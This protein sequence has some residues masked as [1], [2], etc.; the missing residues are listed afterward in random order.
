MHIARG[1]FQGCYFGP[2][3]VID[4]FCQGEVSPID[5]NV[6]TT[7]QYEKLIAQ[8]NQEKIYIFF[9]SYGSRTSFAVEGLLFLQRGLRRP[10]KK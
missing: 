5:A 7:I 2:F 3:G 9:G 6:S 4:V 10:N 8:T 1:P